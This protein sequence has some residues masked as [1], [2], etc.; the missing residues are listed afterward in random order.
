MAKKK[1]KKSLSFLVLPS[2]NIELEEYS[3]KNKIKLMEHVI[4]TIH[5]AIEENLPSVEVFQFKNSDFVI[6]I[7]E[8]EYMNNINNI[9]NYYIKNEKYEYCSKVTQL[10]TMLKNKSILTYNEKK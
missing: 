4:N 6:T 7:S 3:S 9:M 1:E 8:N 5:Y 2:N 10:Q